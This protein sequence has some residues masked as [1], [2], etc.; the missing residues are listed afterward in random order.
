MSRCITRY[1]LQGAPGDRVN[2]TNTGAAEQLCQRERQI[3]ERGGDLLDRSAYQG[4]QVPTT[5][6]KWKPQHVL[7][8]QSRAQTDLKLFC[9]NEFFLKSL[10]ASGVDN[11]GRHDWLDQ[12]PE[13]S[14]SSPEFFMWLFRS[15]CGPGWV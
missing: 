13:P 5:T 7:Q 10:I 1:H 6:R 14:L 2:N 11:E 15:R 3:I 8:P 12:N 9:I 4:L